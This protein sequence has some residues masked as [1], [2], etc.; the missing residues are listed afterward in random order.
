VAD[1]TYY[2]WAPIHHRTKTEDGGPENANVA[3]GE[4]VPSELLD[5]MDKETVEAWISDGVIRTA[6]FP[7]DVPAGVSVRTHLLRKANEAYERAQAIGSPDA[8][9]QPP[10]TEQAIHEQQAAQAEANPAP[11]DDKAQTAPSGTAPT[12]S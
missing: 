8:G 1:K 10:A 4:K 6:K 2:A 12:N 9:E 11:N 5:S 7:D 3:V